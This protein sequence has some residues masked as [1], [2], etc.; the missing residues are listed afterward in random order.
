MESQSLSW[1]GRVQISTKAPFIKQNLKI[2]NK[3]L[4]GSLTQQKAALSQQIETLDQEESALGLS[5]ENLLSRNKLTEELL[6]ILFTRKKLV[7]N[8][9]KNIDFISLNMG[10]PT[11]VSFSKLPMEERLKISSPR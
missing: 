11:L 6:D 1:L 10:M 7:G 8:K 5:E 4:F 2:W 9:N 3:D